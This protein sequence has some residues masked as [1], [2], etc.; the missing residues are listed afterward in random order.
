MEAEW[1]SSD[2]DDKAADVIHQC[3]KTVERD[4]FV[5]LVLH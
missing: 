4:G 2:R 5:A 1:L 3:C